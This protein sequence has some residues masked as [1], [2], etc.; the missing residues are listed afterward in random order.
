MSRG[1]GRVGN[2]KDGT[3]E[4]PSDAS[5][6]G[7]AARHVRQCTTAVVRPTAAAAGGA[8]TGSVEE[9]SALRPV[10]APAS[11]VEPTDS[12]GPPDSDPEENSA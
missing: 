4:R 12:A 6:T 7:V 8:A 11:A 5:D 1:H 2:H 9:K 3:N 10:A